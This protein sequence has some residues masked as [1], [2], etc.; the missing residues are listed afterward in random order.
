MFQPVDLLGE[1]GIREK[2][3]ILCHHGGV[4]AGSDL[5]TSALSL[6]NLWQNHTFI[7]QE[8]Q[9]LLAFDL[10]DGISHATLAHLQ[11]QPQLLENWRY[12]A[13]EQSQIILQMQDA[14]ELIR[15]LDED[16]SRGI[17]LLIGAFHLA[18]GPR[19]GG[20]GV[21]DV[22]GVIWLSPE[23]DWDNVHYAELIVHEYVHQCLFLDDMVYELHL[24]DICRCFRAS[25][26]SCLLYGNKS[27]NWE[28]R[29][30]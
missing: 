22:L 28:R 26:M 15:H 23:D 6:L 3:E 7:F 20:G 18:R 17:D 25:E 30:N 29:A 21:S 9:P 1:A 24:Q 19:S 10:A 13:E 2:L 8:A 5:R 16:V 12:S 27:I 11:Q 4:P 14:F